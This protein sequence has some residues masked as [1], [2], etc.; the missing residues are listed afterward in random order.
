MQA[1]VR[2]G[3]QNPDTSRF[4]LQCGGPFPIAATGQLSAQAVLTGRYA[5]LGLLGKGGMGAVYLAS[6]R[7]ISGKTWAVKEMSDAALQDQKEKSEAIRAFQT[8][9]S[10][11]AT[12][13]H[14]NIP[15]V[16]DYFNEAGRHYLV[17][18][19]VPGETLEAL[20]H[21]RSAPFP[22][23][24][25]VQW[26]A[27]LCDVLAYLHSRQPPVI[28]RDLKPGN[29]MLQPDGT[30]K[31]ID[32]GIARL[33]K[34][35]RSADTMAIGT[36][37]FAA[38]EQH[39][40]AQ[41]DARSD[42]YSLGVMLHYLST[43]H[44]PASDPFNL[45]AAR[46]INPQF[47]P[48]FEGI[49]SRATSLSANSRFASA[50]AMRQV[51]MG[52]QAAVS[53][54]VQASPVQFQPKVQ[55]RGSRW[56]LAA[57]AIVAVLLFAVVIT[58]LSKPTEPPPTTSVAVPPTVAVAESTDT[59]TAISV[60]ETPSR[61]ATDTDTPLPIE[62]RSTPVPTKPTPTTVRPTPT[63]VRQTPTPDL[64]VIKAEVEDT[65]ER[66]AS[67]HDRAVR[68]VREDELP[69]IL[70]GEALE[71]Q[72]GSVRWLRDNNA[73]W[74]VSTYDRRTDAWETVT[75]TWVRVLVWRD[76]KG[77]YFQD[78][79]Y[80]PKSSYRE[81]YQARFVL[82]RIGGKWLIT[83]KGSIEAGKPEPCLLAPP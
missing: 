35:G 67:V 66:W 20:M 36:P 26:G 24:Q 34:P 21:A 10:L 43:G 31:L 71:K 50:A 45:P 83:C 17:M 47:S 23:D 56:S 22:E 32:F 65:L 82:Q 77:D 11:L 18:D 64:A 52:G 68:E 42:I 51:L 59:P 13:D 5:I 46:L 40:R 33:F 25:V 9:A 63:L 73:Y 37:G 62:A 53:R 72:Q 2:C 30:L 57:F 3:H 8:E 80:Y 1:C 29:V 58:F 48:Q 6:D 16:I 14:P 54:G 81:Q 76:E 79:K 44:D 27:Q 7:R 38:P 60:P 39:G 70:D 61:S 78:G 4:C 15:K 75:P 28:F 55:Q 69:A 41:T 19:F 49:L 74:D 12:L